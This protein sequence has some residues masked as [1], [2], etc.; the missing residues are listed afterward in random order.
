MQ[1]PLRLRINVNENRPVPDPYP[2]KMGGNRSMVFVRN[3]EV[4]VAQMKIAAMQAEDRT[5]A[6][7]TRRREEREGVYL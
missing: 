6:T 1:G 3:S 2:R 5:R 4:V 7:V